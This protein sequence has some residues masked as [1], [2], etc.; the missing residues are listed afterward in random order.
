MCDLLIEEIVAQQ[1]LNQVICRMRADNFVAMQSPR[2]VHLGSVCRRLCREI[3]DGNDIQNAPIRESQIFNA[4][5]VFA[6]LHVVR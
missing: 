4:L 2:N 5:R 6:T 1:I 3:R